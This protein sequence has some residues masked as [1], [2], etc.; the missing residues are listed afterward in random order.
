M[1][2]GLQRFVMLS[3]GSSVGLIGGHMID[4][5]KFQEIFASPEYSDK[6]MEMLLND[7]YRSYHGELS[8]EEEAT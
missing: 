7:E 2:G 6:E 5:E 4:E 3:P 8:D 1:T